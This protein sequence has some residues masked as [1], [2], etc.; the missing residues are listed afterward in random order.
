MDWLPRS[1]SANTA[2]TS[3]SSVS[4]MPTMIPEQGESPAAFARSTVSTRSVYSWVVQILA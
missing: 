2:S 1:R 3:S 4:P